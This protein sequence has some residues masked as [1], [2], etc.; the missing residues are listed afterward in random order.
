MNIELFAH[1]LSFREQPQAQAD[2]LAAHGVDGVR[3]A[4]SYRSGRWLLTTSTPC[5]VADF[6]SGR[7]FRDEPAPHDGGRLELPVL[8][9]DATTATAALLE[10]G[11]EVT[12]W[13]V[14]LHQ[15]GPA[16]AHP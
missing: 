8:G 14:G 16:T 15:S 4:F 6:A 2:R 1:P 3:L 7:W 13:L 12:A 9:D 5:A 11:I 10:P